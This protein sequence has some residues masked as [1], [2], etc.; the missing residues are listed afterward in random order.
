MHKKRSDIDLN[1]HFFS[2]YFRNLSSNKV[3]YLL[4]NP[5]SFLGFP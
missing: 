2:Y 5:Q 4:L 1:Y 3:S